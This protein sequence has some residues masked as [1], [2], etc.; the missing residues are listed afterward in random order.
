MGA[1]C[2]FPLDFIL[3]LLTLNPPISELPNTTLSLLILH[4]PCKFF[5]LVP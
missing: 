2:D 3:T 5:P 1:G 4:L